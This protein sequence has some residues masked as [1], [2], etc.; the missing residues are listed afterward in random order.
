MSTNGPRPFL[1]WIG[2]KSSIL[3]S[4][5]EAL[6]SDITGRYFEPFLGGGALLFASK[7]PAGSVAGDLNAELINC[8]KQVRDSLPELTQELSSARFRNS[9]VNYYTIRDWDRASDFSSSYNDIER[10]ARFI[11]LNRL[12]FNGIYRVNR[13]GQYNVPYGGNEQIS[14]L[15]ASRLRQASERL[16]DVS[17]EALSYIDLL[18]KHKPQSGDVVYFDPPYDPI[19]DT[20]AFVGYTKE[21]FAQFDQEN[22]AS[23]AISLAQSGVHVVLSNS[24]TERIRQLY[25][26]D[27]SPFQGKHITL[28]VRRSVSA[29]TLSRGYTAELIIRS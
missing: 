18:K 1:R 16:Q 9:K 4:I 12:G 27:G 25:L 6:P 21:G 3:P 15:D 13:L 19:S 11:F 29:S 7:F 5:L 28:P 8:Y 24:D 22:L 20:S 2:G 17:L 14:V 10:A 23:I 26:F